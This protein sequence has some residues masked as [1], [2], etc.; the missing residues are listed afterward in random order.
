MSEGKQSMGTNEAI[1]LSAFLEA[2]YGQEDMEMYA[3]LREVVQA[4]EATQKKGTLTIKVVVGPAQ[5]GGENVLQIAVDH[6]AQVPRFAPE[7]VL[8]YS[9][10]DGSLSRNDPRQT[11]LPFRRDVDQ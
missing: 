10:A 3:A 2:H 7:T 8:L 5:V 11:V 1:T 4:V 6:T 9:D